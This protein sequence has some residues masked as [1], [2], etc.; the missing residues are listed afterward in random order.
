[1]RAIILYIPE[2]EA[3]SLSPGLSPEHD[4][5]GNRQLLAKRL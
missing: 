3:N 2:I 1:M 5:A 4:Y